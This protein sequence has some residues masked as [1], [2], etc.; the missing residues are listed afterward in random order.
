MQ[1]ACRSTWK[2]TGRL[3][4]ATVDK[5]SSTGQF[6]P[7][8]KTTI[9]YDPR[10]SLA[11]KPSSS[12]S[13]RPFGFFFFSFLFMSCGLQRE[14]RCFRFDTSNFSYIYRTFS[15]GSVSS[16]CSRCLVTYQTSSKIPRRIKATRINEL[17]R[18]M[19]EYLYRTRSDHWHFHSTQLHVPVHHD[20][21]IKIAMV[22]Y[23]AH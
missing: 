9:T 19:T 7:N 6:Q 21:D 1:I 13:T 5:T 3:P 14:T 18:G 10:K 15:T 2:T 17:V 4:G 11:C 23:T 8:A 20:H 12:E 16:R 22:P